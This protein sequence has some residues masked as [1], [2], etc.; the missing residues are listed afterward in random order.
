MESSAQNFLNFSGSPTDQST[1]RLG[2]GAGPR[3][4]SVCKILNEDFV[5]SV[6]PSTPVPPI[7]SVTHV[8]S[9]EKSSLYSLIRINLIILSFITKWSI[10][11]CAPSSVKIPRSMSRCI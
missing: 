1:V 4:L 3:L 10:S 7:D 9:P 2:S 6:L 5:T 11:S 8:G